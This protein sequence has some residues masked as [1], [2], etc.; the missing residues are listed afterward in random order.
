MSVTRASRPLCPFQGSGRRRPPGIPAFGLANRLSMQ[1]LLVDPPP[2][3]GVSFRPAFGL[4][5][6]RAAAQEKTELSGP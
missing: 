1:S 3:C 4:V 2:T 6:C 5:V